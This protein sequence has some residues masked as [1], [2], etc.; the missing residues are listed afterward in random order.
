MYSNLIPFSD[1]VDSIKDAT[2]INNLR[3]RLPQVRRLVNRIQSEIGYGGSMLLKKVNYCT[4]DGTIGVDA[5][6]LHKIKLPQDLV[7]IESVGTCYFG[8]CPEKYNIQ[9]NY[10]FF[11]GVVTEFTL[12]Y[13][14]LICDGEGNPTVTEN[15]FEAVISGLE[16][17]MYKQKIWNKEGNANYLAYLDKYYQDR[18]G[19]ARG[20]DVFPN[21]AKDWEKL[22]VK[23]RMS[24]RDLL[25]YD[26]YEACYNGLPTST[27]N[28]IIDGD[29]D[30]SDDMVYNWQYDDLVS[31][32]SLAPTYDSVFLNLQD[33]D[34]ID[35]WINGTVIN[36]TSVGRIA[37]AIS[38]IPEDYYQIIDVFETDI[39][40]TIFDTYYDSVNSVQYYISKEY[41]SHG[42]IYFKLI[43]N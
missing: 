2:G 8:V 10:I 42:N 26:S 14:A 13:Y 27:N 7:K 17:F 28:E 35:V 30:R 31:D 34:P 5:S 6:G 41:Y 24:Q 16:Y 38:N 9:G 4:E 32:I 15:H 37:F 11:K 43:R 18:I 39:T 1:I 19:E 21:T 29:N 12:V 22:G 3:N 23:L 36:Y 25:I 33:V 20:N 40:S